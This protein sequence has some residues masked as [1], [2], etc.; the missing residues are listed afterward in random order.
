MYGPLVLDVYC[1]IIYCKP[2]PGEEADQN[3]LIKEEVLTAIAYAAGVLRMDEVRPRKR[4]AQ[5]TFS[6]I[7]S[8][9]TSGRRPAGSRLSP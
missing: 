8:T 9:S 3:D 1:R 6:L 4:T 2:R 5:C 7:M